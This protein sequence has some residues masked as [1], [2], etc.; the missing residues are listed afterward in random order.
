M[1]EK[2]PFKK[3][4]SWTIDAPYRETKAE[5]Q[6]YRKEGIGTVEMEAS[7][8]F[9]VAKFRRVKISSAFVVSD[10]LKDNKWNPQFDAKQV[11]QKLYQLFDAAMECL[12]RA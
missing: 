1:E 7:A 9:V 3:S 6:E 10:I 4:A 2:I 11:N 12:S 8:L 5:I